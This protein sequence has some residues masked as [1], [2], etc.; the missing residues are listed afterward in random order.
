MRAYIF[1]ITLNRQSAPGNDIGT[2]ISLSHV[3]ETRESVLFPSVVFCSWEGIRQG[4]PAHLKKRPKSFGEGAAE[5][6]LGRGE[7]ALLLCVFVCASAG[8]AALSLAG[9][10]QQ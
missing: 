2:T 9:S 3:P 1:Y 5:G 8:S 10:A 6:L 7:K 4:P